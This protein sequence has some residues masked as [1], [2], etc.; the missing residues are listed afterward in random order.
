VLTGIRDDNCPA[1]KAELVPDGRHRPSD[2]STGSSRHPDIGTLPSFLPIF[3]IIFSELASQ[4]SVKA[5][6]D[7][8]LAQSIVA[9]CRSSSSGH[10]ATVFGATGFL[11]KY[12]VSKLAKQG[13]Q[14]VIPYRDLSVA[15]PLKV[16]GDLGMTVLQVW[17]IDYPVDVRNTTFGI[18]MPSRGQSSTVIQFTISLDLTMKQ[19]TLY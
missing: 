9:H 3:L 15:L 14:V 7:G 2:Q 12:L 18:R 1:F 16:S 5:Q 17:S 10:I 6:E 19:S 13:T 4:S 11:G 8:M